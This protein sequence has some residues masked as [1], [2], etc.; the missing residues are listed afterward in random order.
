MAE[1][2][3]NSATGQHLTFTTTAAETNGELLRMEI[4][5]DPG[6]H[7]IE[8]VHPV[9]EER[10]EV[11]AGRLSIR[12]DGREDEV[13]PGEAV[14]VPPG[15]AHVWRNHTGEPVRMLAEL[16]PALRTQELQETICAWAEEAGSADGLPANPLRR[17]V[18]AREYRREV[19]SV[20]RLPRPLQSALLVLLAGAGRLLGVSAR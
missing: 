4:V 6:G 14:V 13:G 17:A 3:H 2:I 19:R 11:Q 20:T 8:H 9:Q 18:F 12:V 16:R 15:S 7:S 10:F 5:V 1:C